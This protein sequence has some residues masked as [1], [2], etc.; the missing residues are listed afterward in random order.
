MHLHQLEQ[1]LV[2]A[3]YNAGWSRVVAAGG[4]VPAIE[5]T[6]TYVGR[7][8]RFYRAYGGAAPA[9]PAPLPALDRRRE[10][11]K[12]A[13]GLGGLLALQGLWGW[14]RLAAMRRRRANEDTPY[15]PPAR[16]IA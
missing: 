15:L 7:V 5:E 11:Y 2:A 6:R 16:R 4:R 8:E 3:A 12:L 9:R 1:H 13:G 14:G 10:R